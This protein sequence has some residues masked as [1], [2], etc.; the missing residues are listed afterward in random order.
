[1]N[2]RNEA[3]HQSLRAMQNQSGGIGPMSESSDVCSK[4]GGVM[5]RG[6]VRHNGAPLMVGNLRLEFAIPGVQTSVNP[7]RAHRSVAGL[8]DKEWSSRHVQATWPVP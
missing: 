6:I 5:V 8:C 3:F 7:L 2:H 1:M 4:C